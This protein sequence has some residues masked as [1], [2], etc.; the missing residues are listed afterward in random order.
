MIKIINQVFLAF[1]KINKQT[2]N[3]IRVSHSVVTQD[4]KIRAPFSLNNF[5]NKMECLTV[6]SHYNQPQDYSTIMIVITPQD[7]LTVNKIKA[8]NNKADC[9]VINNKPI[10]L[11]RISKMVYLIIPITTIMVNKLDYLTINNLL[12]I[13]KACLILN[14]I[15]VNKTNKV[16]CLILIKVNNN[17]TTTLTKTKLKQPITTP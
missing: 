10:I 12:T 16:V 3:K 17:P 14:K 8:L 2:N 13:I 6:N 7:Y 9:L 5:Q 4:N 11:S 1:L 15:K